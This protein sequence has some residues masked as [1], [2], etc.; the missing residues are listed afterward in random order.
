MSNGFD[1]DLQ[2]AQAKKEDE[3]IVI[4]IH[5]VDEIPLYYKDH[6]GE[7]KPVTIT[8]AGA[9]SQKY[10]AVERELRKRKIKPKS[11]TSAQAFEDNMHK[12]VVCTLTWEGFNVNGQHVEP[13]AHNVEMVYKR[14][15]WVYDQVVEAM[16]DHAAFFGDGSPSRETISDTEP[17][18]TK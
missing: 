1:I 18:S 4:H 3:G 2:A 6:E 13:T 10:R 15:P 16:H 9:H 12:A 14:C 5:G 11:L 17:S 8:V 7:N